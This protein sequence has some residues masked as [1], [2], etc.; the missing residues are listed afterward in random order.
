M[1]RNEE[2]LRDARDHIQTQQH[3]NYLLSYYPSLPEGGEKG[4]ERILEEIIVESVPNIREEI[5]TRGRKC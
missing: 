5:A 3:S 2:S 4:S 1:K